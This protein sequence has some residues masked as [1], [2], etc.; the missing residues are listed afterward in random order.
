MKNN[1]K[2]KKLLINLEKKNKKEDEGKKFIKNIDEKIINQKIIA[3]SNKIKQNSQEFGEKFDLND[4]NKLKKVSEIMKKFKRNCEDS[5]R[6]FS[7][8]ENFENSVEKKLKLDSIKVNSFLEKFFENKYNKYNE[9]P[10]KHIKLD[11]KSVNIFSFKKKSK[12]TE[13]DEV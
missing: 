3:S 7:D 1:E 9:T 4:K 5:K 2:K 6:S 11:E 8:E 13:T 12:I 10:K